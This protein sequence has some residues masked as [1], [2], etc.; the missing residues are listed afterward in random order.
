MDNSQPLLRGGIALGAAVPLLFLG[1]AMAGPYLILM[2]AGALTVAA[3]GIRHNSTRPGPWWLIELGGVLLLLSLVSRGIHAAASGQVFPFPSPADAFAVSGY[4]LLLA[5]GTLLAHRR[6]AMRGTGDVAA[7]VLFGLF[8]AMPFW[9]VVLSPYVDDST[10]STGHEALNIAYSVI[11]IALITVVAQLA[12]GPGRRNPSYYLFT[13]AIG[14]IIALDT[15]AVL[16]SVGLI[17]AERLLMVLAVWG[18]TLFTAAM[19]DPRLDE[20]DSH[21]DPTDPRLTSGRLLSISLGFIL[22]SVVTS[23]FWFTTRGSLAIIPATL[24]VSA[25]A[26]TLVRI[27]TL[28]RSRAT[29]R[30]RSRHYRPPAP[31]A[32]RTGRLS[33]P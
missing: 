13:G 32:C 5:G 20:L 3:L 31:T 19:L 18:F 12:T 27:V 24:M 7:A 8:V 16:E 28:F 11:D 29:Y 17:D 6:Q 2:G 4:L 22:T 15:F 21:P 23:Y 1:E 10:F 26:L 9:L 33:D 25:T 14:S 30:L